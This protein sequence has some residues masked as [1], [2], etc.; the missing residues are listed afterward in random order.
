VHPRFE[1]LTTL[2]KLV[3]GGASFTDEPVEW[4]SED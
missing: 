3:G 4:S 2:R 1:Y